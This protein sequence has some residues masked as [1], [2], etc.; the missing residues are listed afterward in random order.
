ML[1]IVGALAARA[2]AQT[3]EELAAWL[4]E[5][6]PRQGRV[7]LVYR[8]GGS[9]K[10]TQYGFDVATRAWYC[11]FAGTV[12]ARDPAGRIHRSPKPYAKV[13]PWEGRPGEVTDQIIEQAIP[14][15]ILFD[16]VERPSIAETVV[17]TDGGG[18]EV[19]CSFPMGQRSYTEETFAGGYRPADRTLTYH[20]SADARLDA[21]EWDN[22]STLER[23]RYAADLPA[24]GVPVAARYGPGDGWQLIETQAGEQPDEFRVDA[25]IERAEAS[26]LLDGIVRWSLAGKNDPGSSP[27]AGNGDDGRGQPVQQMP[28]RPKPAT[29]NWAALGAGGVF[30]GVG[31]YAWVRR[32]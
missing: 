13:E 10:L 5:R 4:K 26:G 28:A 12:I 18:W 8:D 2:G 16:L 7:H 3:G 29:V 20:I 21:V 27:P 17:R 15:V 23:V 31:I 19:T 14:L 32:R 30:I 25:V 9:G 1:L 22:S 11:N 24:P 6:L